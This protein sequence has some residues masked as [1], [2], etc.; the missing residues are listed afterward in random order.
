ML[1]KGDIVECLR[2]IGQELKNQDMVGEIL[3]TG[4][5]AMCLVHSARDM[6]KDIDALYEPKT[7]INQIASKIA[8]EKNL[9]PD[10]L[11]DSVKGFVT[12]NVSTEEFMTFDGLKVTVVS[13]EY[14]LAMKL[15]SARYGE[16]DFE[17][18]VFL[19][20]KLDVKTPDQ[21]ERII[22]RFYP[23]NRILPKTMY[24]IEEC[25]E[26]CLRELS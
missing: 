25:L 16:K 9:P 22:T 13:P 14:L 21:A 4:G 10:W 5:A 1:S 3:L 12:E 18:I 20:R 15:I 8:E 11:N 7:L 6:T 2:E 26:E 17:D 24:V 19:L 23:V